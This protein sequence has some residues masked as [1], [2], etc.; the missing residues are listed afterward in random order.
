[1]YPASDIVAVEP[2]PGLARRDFLKV[3]GGFALAL[4]VAGALGGC[5]ETT[6]APEPGFTFLQAG[7]VAL[8]SALAPAVVD[9]LAKLDAGERNARV[10]KLLRNLDGTCSALGMASQKELRKLLDL[11]AIA[12]IRY[13]L[14]G[15]GAW[16]EASIETLQAF[17]TRWRGS[18]FATLNAG[19][20]VLVKLTSSSYYVLP[21]SWPATGYP[22]PLAHVFSAINS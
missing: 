11:M 10:A 8:F 17:L 3:G 16:N 12:P 22:G 13:V 5:S 19:G 14:G 2:T 20:N 18:R 9:E 6:K 21:V 7:D 1:M 15:V 4:T